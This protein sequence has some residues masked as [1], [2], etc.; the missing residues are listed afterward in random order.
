MTESDQSD[1]D[2]EF[3]KNIKAEAEA[4]RLEGTARDEKGALRMIYVHQINDRVASMGRGPG[5]C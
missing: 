1:E 5:R 2:D 3:S 4:A